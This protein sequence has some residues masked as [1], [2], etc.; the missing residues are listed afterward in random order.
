MEGDTAGTGIK[1]DTSGTWITAS[2]IVGSSAV[3]DGS[4]VKGFRSRINWSCGEHQV[5]PDAIAIFD[6]YLPDFVLVAFI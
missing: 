4:S 2:S 6:T 5:E 1:S 3:S